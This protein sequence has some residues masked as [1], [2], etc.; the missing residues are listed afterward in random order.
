MELYI[1]ADAGAK[2]G[3]EGYDFVVNRR[4]LSATHTL[5]Q[6]LARDGTTR[7]VGAISYAVRGKELELA[8]PKK[9]LGLAGRWTF[10][11]DFHWADNIQAE[12][13][14]IEF[15]R[16]GAHHRAQPRACPLG[17]DAAGVPMEQCIGT[18]CGPRRRAG[19]SGP[20]PRARR[21]DCVAGLPGRRCLRGA[22]RAIPSA[23]AHG[24]PTGR[25][26]VRDPSGARAWPRTSPPEARPER[27]V[28]T[29][30]G[31]SAKELSM[32]SPDSRIHEVGSSCAGSC[33][34][35]LL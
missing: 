3:W 8:V 17:G 22:G 33:F 26:G 14:I 32:V 31:T 18:P 15:A 12:R 21:R 4:V 7:R 20:G 27:P 35:V 30:G 1:D 24:S 28:E 34:G 13:D 23:R 10:T 25:C 6:G 5:M 16:R 11:L 2:T 19:A 29:Q 9:L